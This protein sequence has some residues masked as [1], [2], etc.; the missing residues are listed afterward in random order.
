MWRWL[1]VAT[2]EGVGIWELATGRQRAIIQVGRNSCA[3][4]DAV[5]GGISAGPAGPR[6]W[7]LSTAADGSVRV[8]P[9]ERLP[10]P[11]VFAWLAG[12]PNGRVF[13]AVEIDKGVVVDRDRPGRPVPLAPLSNARD[14]VVSPDGRRVVTGDHSGE[15]LT[16]W[17]ADTGRMIRRLCPGHLSR[18]HFSL[19]GRLLAG[20]FAN[21][22]GK[23]FEGRVWD[24]ETWQELA[25]FTG[26]PLAFAPDGAV[27]AVETGQ[28]E[29]RLL[30]PKTAA[31]IARLE[32]PNLDRADFGCFTPDG[33]GLVMSANDGTAVHVWDLRLI[34]TRLADRGFDWN[35]PPYPPSN[36]RKDPRPVQP[37]ASGS[38]D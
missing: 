14:V 31:E 32:D 8:G 1:A 30:V 27:V 2:N 11:G 20:D 12:T 21:T 19:D 35:L 23:A 26:M 38:R 7:P 37:I 5:G 6:R 10:L 13:A 28:G 3:Q 4:F 15:G 22:D 9:F 24:T 33:A 36:G 17:D 34:R 16:V 25:R 29:V 18:S